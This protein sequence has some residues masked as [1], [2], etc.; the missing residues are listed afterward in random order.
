MVRYTVFSS[1]SACGLV[2]ARGFVPGM[3]CSG[4]FLALMCRSISLTVKLCTYDTGAK[5]EA[6]WKPGVSETFSAALFWAGFLDLSSKAAGTVGV[7]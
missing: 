4:D 5:R 2:F 1:L 7:L 6:G 3:V